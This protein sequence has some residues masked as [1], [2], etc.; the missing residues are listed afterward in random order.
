M[1]SV[2]V[3]AYNLENYIQRCIT[4]ILNQSYTDFEL[5]IVNDSSKDKTLKLIK[6]FTDK[7]IIIINNHKNVGAGLSRRYGIEKAIGDYVALID[8]DD[9]IDKDYLLNLVTRAEET[10]A[11]IVSEGMRYDFSNGSYRIET[12]GDIISEGIDKFKDYDKQRI[13]FLNNKIVRRSL[14]N[15]VKYSDKR[16]CEDTPVI[17]PLLYYANKVAYVN[18]ANYH[19]VQHDESLCHSINQNAADICKAVCA[20][21]LIEFFADKEEEV[22]NI[23]PVT[24]FLQFIQ[25]IRRRG[26]KEDDFKGFEKE[27]IETMNYFIN[28]INL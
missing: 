7:R 24:Q 11:D 22:R 3:T 19:Y 16:Y 1:V 8:G 17:L 14:Y 27:Y 15:L 20:K 21:N 10:D 18:E 2:V 5:I 25:Q 26:V 23:I 28:I 9:Y 12:F 13:V 6:Q 4:S